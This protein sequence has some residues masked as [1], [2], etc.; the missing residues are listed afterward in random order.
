LRERVLS[1]IF[2]TRPYVASLR[3]F[4]TGASTRMLRRFI[5]KSNP[6]IAGVALA[7]AA[8]PFLFSC[9]DDEGPTGPTLPFNYRHPDGGEWIYGY[10]SMEFARYVIAG[11]YDHPAGGETQKLYEYV[12][13]RSGWE[14]SFV[15]YLKVGADD[16][17]I[18]ADAEAN[19]F[20]VL[21]KFPLT[22]GGSWDAGLGLRGTFVAVEKVT[23]SAGTFNCAR[24]AYTGGPG[25]FTVWWA[26]GAGGWG[27]RNA[28]WWAL[29]GEPIV[30]ELGWYNLPT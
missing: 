8:V 18:Y 11:T 19:Q 2:I 3:Y 28:G 4:G 30:L 9:G 13:G 27:A 15:Y 22:Q 29:G 6:V 12:R 23:V 24:V 1:V 20:I 26:S 16:V 14:E 21:L 7:A 25:T 10:E 17:K 5:Q